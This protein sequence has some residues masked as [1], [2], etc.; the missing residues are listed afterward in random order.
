[1]ILGAVKE[2]LTEDLLT[3]IVEGWEGRTIWVSGKRA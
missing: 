1:M 2:G 3:A